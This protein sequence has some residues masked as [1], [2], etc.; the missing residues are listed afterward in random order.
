[1]EDNVMDVSLLVAREGGLQGE[2]KGEEV[3]TVV[4][5]GYHANSLL[6]ATKA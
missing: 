3:P 5:K 6:M 1:M 4:A 2:G